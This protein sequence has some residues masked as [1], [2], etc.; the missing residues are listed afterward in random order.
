MK[1]SM[2][3]LWAGKHCVCPQARQ[4][5]S[6]MPTLWQHPEP[7]LA[8]FSPYKKDDPLEA[9][10]EKN[11]TISTIVTLFWLWERKLQYHTEEQ[12]GFWHSYTHN[13][14]VSWRPLIFLLFPV[15]LRDTTSREVLQQ[16]LIEDHGR[17]G[18]K[19]YRW[20]WEKRLD[21]E[22]LS[23]LFVLLSCWQSSVGM[24]GLCCSTISCYF[25]SHGGRRKWAMLY[26]LQSWL[27]LLTNAKHLII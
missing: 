11:E 26:A 12:A 22:R 8:L 27:P 19:Q 18:T 13:S 2:S 4:S 7:N 6:L 24:Y 23:Y 25:I 17:D 15:P 14:A 3:V 1:V 9:M 10:G 21:D 16:L 5:F 20:S